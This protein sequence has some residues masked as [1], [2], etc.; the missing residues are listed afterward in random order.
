MAKCKYRREM[1][2]IAKQALAD[3]YSKEATAGI[4]GITKET[5]YQWIKGKPDF[6][7]AIEAGEA[8]SQRWWEDKGREACT[9]G[10]FNASVWSMNMKNRFG[11]SDK[12]THEHTGSDGGPLKIESTLLEVV[13][14]KA[15]DDKS[16]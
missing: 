6:S 1:C 2:E 9:D 3:G 4:L 11:W 15:G 16:S 8:L 10:Q 7:D 5:F 12:S 14:V 13:G